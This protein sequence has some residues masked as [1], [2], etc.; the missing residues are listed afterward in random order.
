MLV[1]TAEVKDQLCRRIIGLVDQHH[2]KL[3]EDANQE[4]LRARNELKEVFDLKM[5]LQAMELKHTHIQ[6]ALRS[7]E[8]ALARSE[9]E[10]ARLEATI[11]QI[12]PRKLSVMKSMLKRT[13]CFE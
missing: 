5:R 1:V 7:S 12:L 13:H 4:L 2:E 10:C 11:V 8:T 3:H 9:A 6:S